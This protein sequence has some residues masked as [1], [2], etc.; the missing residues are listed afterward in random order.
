MEQLTIAIDF[1]D[2]F[3]AAPELW[4]SFI[5]EAMKQGHRVICVS[6]FPPQNEWCVQH[7]VSK[8]PAGVTVYGSWG[9]KKRKFMKNIHN[10]NVD[11]WIDD[12]PDMIVGEENWEPT[13]EQ[14]KAETVVIKKPEQN[15]EIEIN[16]SAMK[17]WFGDDDSWRSKFDYGYSWSNHENTKT[18]LEEE[19]LNEFVPTKV[20]N[21]LEI[22]VGYG[23][24][25]K[26]IQHYCNNLFGTD[27]NQNCVDFCKKQLP[28][29]IF[30]VTD[31]VSIPFKDTLFDIIF[32]FDS[33]V[34][35]NAVIIE[36]YINQ[37][38][39]RLKPNGIAMIHHSCSGINLIEGFKHDEGFGV[40]NRTDMTKELMVEFCNR[41]G[42]K[43][44][45]Q[46]DLYLL[47]NGNFNDTFTVFG[48]R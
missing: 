36:K 19:F 31:G 47:P 39:E 7:R 40:G 8:L 17:Q 13:P 12:T 41:N 23:R 35:A 14:I 26:I 24:A 21:L 22:A 3:T 42:L 32:S 16:L 2:T 6:A 43:I 37:I 4:T 25:T 29:G 30:E 11:I 20:E 46:K 18:F 10:I 5:N 15:S 45:K 27:L 44:I 33:L 9:N 28:N 38:A 48:K 34:H 1:G